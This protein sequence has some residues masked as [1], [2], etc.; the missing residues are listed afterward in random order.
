MDFELLKGRWNNWAWIIVVYLDEL[1][2]FTLF[3]GEDAI[4]RSAK[5]LSQPDDGISFGGNR[6]I[7]KKKKKRSNLRKTGQSQFSL[8]SHSSVRNWAVFINPKPSGWAR[9]FG[10][11]VYWG[12]YTGIQYLCL[13]LGI[14][15]YVFFLEFWYGVYL[16]WK[17]NIIQC[18]I[19]SRLNLD[20]EPYFNWSFSDSPLT[21]FVCRALSK[22][23]AVYIQSNI[24]NFR[25]WPPPWCQWLWPPRSAIIYR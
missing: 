5:E 2:S 18:E 6:I 25:M 1:C 7:K 22:T 3:D 13:K 9:V 23:T 12:I 8:L 15:F 16:I 19:K 14:K 24:Q 10:Y 11:T 17:I 21:A 20:G 4:D